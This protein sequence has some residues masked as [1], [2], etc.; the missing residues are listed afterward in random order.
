MYGGMTS[1]QLLGGDKDW[2]GAMGAYD[3]S[4]GTSDNDE[5]I[6]NY[7]A[8][9]RQVVV[10]GG[11]VNQRL[12]AIFGLTPKSIGSPQASNDI[13]A[14]QMSDLGAGIWNGIKAI[15]SGI[16]NGLATVAD[17]YRGLAYLVTNNIN[18]FQPRS[19][20]TLDGIARGIVDNSPVGVLG[21]MFDNNYRAA[22]SRFVGTVAGLG[23]SYASPYLTKI[24]GLNYDIGAASAR[25]LY[26]VGEYAAS[27]LDVMLD[28]SGLRAYAFPADASLRGGPTT[29]VDAEISALKRIAAN[30]AIDTRSA[31][32]VA[33]YGVSFFGDDVVPF[34]G[35]SKAT[36]GNPNGAPT[37]SCRL[38]MP[39]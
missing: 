3:G 29:L 23:T 19:N 4:Y 10:D 9:I 5:R 39:P 30:N 18:S 15:P 24:P 7:Q 22:G 20:V 11:D 2:L 17:G 1:S 25:G 34:Y 13:A 31:A 32:R 28:R 6:P 38:K 12:N 26:S 14:Q 27:K 16:W 8:P 36:V 35:A 21:A 33:R 37:F